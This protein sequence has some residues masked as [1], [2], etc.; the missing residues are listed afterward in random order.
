MVSKIKGAQT[1]RNIYHFS[2]E[3]NLFRTKR[4]FAEQR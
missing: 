3:Q 4:T 1:R 2:G